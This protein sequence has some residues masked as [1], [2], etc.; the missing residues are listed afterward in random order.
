[1]YELED[2]T[3]TKKIDYLKSLGSDDVKHSGSTLLRHLIGVHDLLKE[4]D[5]PKY[6]QDAGLFHSVYGTPYFK[7]IMTVDR[8]AV[9]ELIGTHAEALAAIFC[10]MPKPRLDVINN[11][12]NELIR[13][14]LNLLYSANV[15]DMA[16]SKMLTWEEAYNYGE[17]E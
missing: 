14:D 16:A 5:A 10:F 17:S 8:N 11:E 2:S 13:N 1:M 12:E 15:N 6:L 9:R 7:P 4:W 3:F